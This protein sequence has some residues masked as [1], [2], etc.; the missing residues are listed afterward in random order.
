PVIASYSAQRD[1]NS[2]SS[3][4]NQIWRNNRKWESDSSLINGVERRNEV[5][6]PV[7]KK[8]ILEFKRLAASMRLRNSALY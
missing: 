5:P 8:R 4:I 1:A 3:S 7:A 6:L 2:H